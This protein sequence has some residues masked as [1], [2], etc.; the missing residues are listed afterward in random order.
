MPAPCR[1]PWIHNRPPVRLACAIASSI[2]NL[3][4]GKPLGRSSARGNRV[5]TVRTSRT[6]HCR[7]LALR[8]PHSRSLPKSPNPIPGTHRTL[9]LVPA[10][11]LFVR[12]VVFRASLISDSS[13]ELTAASFGNA[14]AT[15]GLRT[16]TFD[17]SRRRFAYFPLTSG[18]E[19]SE[20]WYSARKSSFSVG[21][22]FF[23][24]PVF[25]LARQA[26]A[27]DTDNISLLRM[28]NYQEPAAFRHAEGDVSTLDNRMVRVGAGS[29]QGVAQ[30]RGCL[31]KRD[32][33]FP[34]IRTG[35]LPIP[36]QR[37]ARTIP[38]CGLGRVPR[39]ARDACPVRCDLHA[40][41]R[42]FWSMP[43]THRAR[44]VSSSKS[45]RSYCT[46]DGGQFKSA[47]SDRA[48]LCTG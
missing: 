6:Q 2:W 33:V 34:Q 17:A 10:L 48:P 31:F 25:S 35:L 47:A 21:L 36:F 19:K 16:T 43:A 9:R 28:S 40:G 14:S 11:R 5:T 7:M 41:P 22:A 3:R 8:R 12:L 30:G 4:S 23:I 44:R 46:S 39:E 37:H 20:R 15:S 1:L 42:T 26:S 32:A 38:R 45:P 29:G 18:W 13:A 24:N 27:N